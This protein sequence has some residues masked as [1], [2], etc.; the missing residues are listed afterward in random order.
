YVRDSL[1]LGA[2]Y[3]VNPSLRLYGEIGVGAVDG[4]AEPVELQFG[5]EW[6]QA[7]NTGLRGGPFIAVNGDLRQE[8]A[9]GGNITVQTGWM[10]RQFARGANFRIGAQYFYGKSDEYEF[11]RQTESRIGWGLWYDF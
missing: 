6:A 5:F 2:G 10:W 4:G 9:Y 8:V 11:F 7:R 3:F 1:I